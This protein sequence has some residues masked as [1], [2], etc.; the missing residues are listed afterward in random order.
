[1][2]WVAI[3]DDN[4]DAGEI[5]DRHSADHYAY[6][7]GNRDAILLAGGLRSAPGERPCG[8]LWVLEV[9]SKAQ[10]V[11]LIERD[12]FVVHGLRRGYRLLLWGKAPGFDRVEL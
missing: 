4:E 1:M 5:R 8:G 10:A 6:L 2:R 11:E 9:E 3:F 7:D 12:P